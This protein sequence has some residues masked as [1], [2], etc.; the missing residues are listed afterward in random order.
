MCSE[1][2]TQY[3]V[4][5]GSMPWCDISLT[6]EA[7][8]PTEYT[9]IDSARVDGWIRFDT[10]MDTNINSE[11]ILKA[12]NTVFSLKDINWGTDGD[13]DIINFHISAIGPGPG[14]LSVDAYSAISQGGILILAPLDNYPLLNSSTKGIK[15]SIISIDTP[16][17]I[18]PK[19]VI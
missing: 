9:V 4:T 14:Y 5:D 6:L 1:D 15:M 13:Y 19:E 7:L 11:Q 3:D 2:R 12:D 16:C 17:R 8:Y 10:R 18:L